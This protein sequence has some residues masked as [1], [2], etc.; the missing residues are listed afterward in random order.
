MDTAEMGN[1]SLPNCYR[2]PYLGVLFCGDSDTEH[3]WQVRRARAS[4]RFSELREVWDDET[5]S[6]TTKLSLYRSLVVSVLVY[7]YE[8]WILDAA[9][10]RSINGFNSRC[11]VR[12]TG[13]EYREEAKDPTF[14]LCLYLRS[15]RLRFLGHVLRYDEDSMVRQVIVSRGTAHRKG[16]LFMDTPAHESIADLT[17]I[18]RDKAQWRLHVEE[19][20]GNGR[21]ATQKANTTAETAAEIKALPIGSTLA[22]TDGGCDGNGANGKWGSAGWGAWIAQKRAQD[23]LPLSDLWGPVTINPDD[24]FYCGCTGATNNT[25][26]LT[27]M[28]NALLWAKQQGGH[29]AFAI[30][31]DS[32]YAKNVTSGVWKPRKNQ[33][34]SKLCLDAFKEEDER[35][36]GGV[37][38]IHV[39]GHSGDT[40]NDKADDRVQWGKEQGPYCRFRSD[41]SAEGDFIHAPVSPSTIPVC[42]TPSPSFRLHFNHPANRSS[43]DTAPKSR[44]T[45]FPLGE[46]SI[47]PILPPDM[48]SDSMDRSTMALHPDSDRLSSIN[49]M[50]S[51]IRQR[52]S[53]S[54]DSSFAAL[55]SASMT[56]PPDLN[57]TSSSI[58]ISLTAPQP[59]LHNNNSNHSTERASCNSQGTTSVSSRSHNYF[60][61]S[62]SNISNKG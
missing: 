40:G 47:S 3:N 15:Q 31:Y 60:T 44:R 51:R 42:C 16:D 22:Y 54:S 53:L 55:G 14:D 33:G 4:A 30:C 49:K 45:L 26:E 6:E 62:R 8:G 28:L 1:A 52:T 5:L 61:R 43:H 48:P 17:E 2:F 59:V 25:G 11:L 46:E 19:L 32:V 10:L 9:H 37:T 7:G 18:A 21:F 29:E 12:I 36:S 13:R 23:L 39:K 50:R 41:G 35:R 56:S 20:A 58:S 27:G 57:H 38:F 24:E 34:I